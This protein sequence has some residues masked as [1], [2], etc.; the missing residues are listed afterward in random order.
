MKLTLVAHSERTKLLVE[1]A[2]LLKYMDTRTIFPGSVYRDVS[3]WG[4]HW[5]LV[6]HHTWINLLFYLY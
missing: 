1:F 2:I 3:F 4:I 6:V 5:I